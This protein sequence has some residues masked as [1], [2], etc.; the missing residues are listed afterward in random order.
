MDTPF[1]QRELWDSTTLSSADALQI[2]ESRQARRLSVRVFRS[3][4]V[5]VVVPRRT[6]SR[7]VAHF[8]AEHREWIDAKRAL[9]QRHAPPPSPF[10][11]RQ[12]RFEVNDTTWRLHLSGGTGRPRIQSSSGL[13][14]VT[15]TVSAETLRALLRRWLLVAARDALEPLVAPLAQQMGVRFSAVH[16]RRQRTRWGSCSTR[17]VISLNACLVFQPPEVVRYLLVHELTHTVH[18]NHS[19]RFWAAVERF[20]P[21]WRALDRRLLEGWRT[22]PAWVFGEE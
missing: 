3:G 18:M 5:E 4:R 12:V 11:P 2:R 10:P 6:P 14:H 21:G 19:R 7:L 15:G 17:G 8:L 20:E 16:V 9:A 22:V 13:L 1:Q